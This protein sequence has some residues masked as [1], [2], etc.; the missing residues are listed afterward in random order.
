MKQKI[1][2][3]VREAGIRSVSTSFAFIVTAV[4]VVAGIYV[5][6]GWTEPSVSAPGGNLGAPINTSAIPQN[7]AGSL[8]ISGILSVL[9]DVSVGGKIDAIGDV[10]TSVTGEKKCLSSSTVGPGSTQIKIASEQ[11]EN[12]SANS[13]KF[14]NLNSYGFTEK[15]NVIAAIS[16]SN[17]NGVGSFTVDH[18]RVETKLITKSSFE[19][20]AYSSSWDTG[21]WDAATTVAWMAIGY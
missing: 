5:A 6:K 2:Q 11:N 13:C 10:C 14:I 17:T 21:A 8:G 19:V 7:K 3:F 1:K 20:C 12:V 4:F 16:D 18:F 15:P 9:S